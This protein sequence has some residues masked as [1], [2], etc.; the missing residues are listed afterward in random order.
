[1][2][3]NQRRILKATIFIILAMLAFPPFHSVIRGIIRNE[4]YGFIF[5]PPVTDFLNVVPTVDV[6]M[7]LLQWIGVFIVGGLSFLLAKD[8]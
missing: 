8:S 7:L 4:G 1:M 6:S 3:A 5:D 2:N